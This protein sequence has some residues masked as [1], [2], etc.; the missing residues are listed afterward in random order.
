MSKPLFAGLLALMLSSPLWAADPVYEVEVVVFSKNLAQIDKATLPEH[1]PD[2]DSGFSLDMLGGLPL[3]TSMLD[4]AVA[5][6]KA[7]SNYQVLLHQ[8]WRQPV[9]AAATAPALH[10]SSGTVKDSRGSLPELEGLVR[11]Y[12]APALVMDVDMLLRKQITDSDAA[13]N[14]ALAASEDN[15]SQ[16][17][18]ASDSSEPAPAPDAQPAAE[19]V[20]IPFTGSN[21][22]NDNELVYFDGPQLG[23]LAQIKA[24]NNQ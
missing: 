7:N 5:K 10:L 2:L 24:I 18:G 20:E 21:K 4:S 16:Y 14:T 22:L 6:L 17:A 13:N 15:E 11:L 23:V 8:A 3:D 19:L 12:R 1:K 9:G